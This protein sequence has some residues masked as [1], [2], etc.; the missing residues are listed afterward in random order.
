MILDEADRLLDSGFSD[1]L[2]DISELISRGKRQHKVRWMFSA[3]WADSTNEL[4]LK[5]LRF[6]HHA[7]ITM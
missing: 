1:D 5:L 4:A 7:C 6:E 2:I 3:T